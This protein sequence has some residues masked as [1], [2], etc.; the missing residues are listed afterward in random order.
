[1]HPRWY[2][3]HL[4]WVMDIFIS[5]TQSMRSRGNLELSKVSLAECTRL[6][7]WGLWCGTIASAQIESLVGATTINGE[8]KHRCPFD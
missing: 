5:S 6:A 8:S 2:L 7:D 4:L 1:M 3:H